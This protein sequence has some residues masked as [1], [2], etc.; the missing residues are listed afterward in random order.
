MSL[1]TPRAP[2]SYRDDPAVPAFDDA[3]PIV[4]MD[5]ECALCSTAARTIARLDRKEELRICPVQTDLGRAIAVHYGLDPNQQDT[6]LYLDG[7]RAWAASEA[8]IR[9]GGRL[10]GL[11]RLAFV[12]RILPRP[13]RDRLYRRIALNRYRLFGRTDMCAIPDPQ[14]QRRLMR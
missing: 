6:W 7:G 4:F 9:A 2:F 5:A 3:G 8:V 13:A 1:L 12:L 10:G 14:L 11:G